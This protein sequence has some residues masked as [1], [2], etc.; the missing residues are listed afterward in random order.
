[1]VRFKFAILVLC[2]GSSASAQD[3]I[4]ISSSLQEPVRLWFLPRGEKDWSRPPVFL[5]RS[6]SVKVILA[7][8]SDYWLVAKDMAG[9]EDY[10]GWI[11]LPKLARVVPPVELIVGG[12]HVTTVKE[13]TRTVIVYE[14]SQEKRKQIVW[15]RVRVL[16]SDGRLRYAWVQREI[17]V[18][19]NILVPVEKLER[20]QIQVRSLRVELSLVQGG[21]R[22]P[23]GQ[24]QK[25][26][27]VED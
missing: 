13:I 4:Q 16:G 18:T 2:I 25:K 5:P 12:G 19:V 23:I 1:M 17:E 10:L 15:E 27:R 22:I 9:D 6:G 3:S 7:H 8:Q 26:E 14:T 20:L 24:F 11:D 21:Q